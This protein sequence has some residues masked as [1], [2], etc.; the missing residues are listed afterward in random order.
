LSYGTLWTETGKLGGK[1]RVLKYEAYGLRGTSKRTAPR[2][3]KTQCNE[4]K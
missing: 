1:K 3:G 2:S 4:V